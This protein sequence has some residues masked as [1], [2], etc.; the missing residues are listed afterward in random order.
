MFGSSTS[1][2]PALFDRMLVHESTSTDLFFMPLT[3]VR[4]SFATPVPREDLYTLARKLTNAVEKLTSA[5]HIL[6]L[7]KIDGFAPHITAIL[8]II[9]RQ[10]VLTE[11]VIPKLIDVRGLD[12]YW[13][14]MLRISRQAVRTAEEYD[15]QLA[16]R[17]PMER[18]RR[19]TKF[20]TRLSAAANAMRDVSAEIG[21]II[22]QES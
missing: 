12:T 4:S 19:Y 17:Y 13:M 10:A 1:E 5:A 15:A 8:D 7:H 11:A 14:D 3:T 2:Y 9:Q 6:Y 22:V 20:I 18:Y 16:A 21:R